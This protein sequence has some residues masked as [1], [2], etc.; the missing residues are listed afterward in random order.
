MDERLQRRPGG[1]LDVAGVRWVKILFRG[2]G[3]A[4]L[5]GSLPEQR[6]VHARGV[7]LRMESWFCGCGSTVYVG[8]ANLTKR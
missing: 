2:L 6:G 1:R 8:S 4:V 3:S 7:W 5:V